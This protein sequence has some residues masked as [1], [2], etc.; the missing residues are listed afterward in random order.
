MPAQL[1]LVGNPAR[2][3]A[4][5]K[6][7]KAPSA[8][9][10]RARAKFAAMARARA[11]KSRRVHAKRKIR[12]TAVSTLRSNPVRHRRHVAKRS[13]A[14]ARRRT[15]RNPINSA[16]LRNITTLLKTSATGAAGAIGVDVIM[17]FVQ[18]YLP[19]SL[20]N[21]GTPASPNYGYYAAKGALAVGTAMVASKIIGSAKAARIAE[22]S[23][24]VTLHDLF[25]N[26]IAGN[27][28]SIPLGMYTGLGNSPG[29]KVLPMMNAT[30]NLRGVGAYVS[31][32]NSSR[33]RETLVR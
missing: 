33:R 28:S 23:M 2:R 12:R 26:L 21:P 1:L 29:G 7:T 11:G 25:R 31:S 30:R 27:V 32:P 3:K 17:G 16:T 6:S 19:A 5:R 4:R 14:V 20:S 8:A 22:G 10:R 18:G 24:T 15:R 13:H 9:Q